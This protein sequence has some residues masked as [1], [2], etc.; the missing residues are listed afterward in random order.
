MKYYQMVLYTIK[1][2]LAKKKTYL[3]DNYLVVLT[4]TLKVEET[5]LWKNSSKETLLYP[6]LYLQ[7]PLFGVNIFTNNKN[8]A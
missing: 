8:N 3:K 1:T 7:N 6:L 4:T 5:A 2:L